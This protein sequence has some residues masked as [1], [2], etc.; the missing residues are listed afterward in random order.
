MTTLTEGLIC[1]IYARLLALDRVD[2]DD[3]PYSL[4]CDS[5][6][7]VRIALEIEKQFGVDIPLEIMEASGV[8][9]EVAAW[10]DEQ[11]AA[12]ETGSHPA[13]AA[14]TALG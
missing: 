14:G 9:R 5:Q 12:A 11:R 8:V 2:P 4:G 6:Q 3:D 13:G 1:A 7:A 10:V